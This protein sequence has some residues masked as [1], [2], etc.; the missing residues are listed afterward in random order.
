MTLL[1]RETAGKDKKTKLFIT[2]GE[3]VDKNHG[4]GVNSPNKHFTLRSHSVIVMDPT[5]RISDYLKEPGGGYT[6]RVSSPGEL[7]AHELLGHGLNGVKYAPKFQ[8]W[9]LRSP[10]WSHEDAIQMGN[11]YLRTQGIG[12]Y[13]DGKSHFSNVV[14]AESIATGIP[15]SVQMPSVLQKLIDRIKYPRQIEPARRDGTNPLRWKQR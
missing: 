9:Q 12:V 5:K 1:G 2:N 15:R 14:L 13:R 8:K 3:G 11:L 4:G 10:T 6:S 7:L